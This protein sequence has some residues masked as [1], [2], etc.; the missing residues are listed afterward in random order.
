MGNTTAE[1][2]TGLQR[3]LTAASETAASETAASQLPPEAPGPWYGSIGAYCGNWDG[4]LREWCFTYDTAQCAST[5]N[6]PRNTSDG[7]QYFYSSGPCG[8]DVDS[9]SEYILDG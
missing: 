5:L 1:A 2:D 3:R 9:R 8:N 4:G 6:T 7:R